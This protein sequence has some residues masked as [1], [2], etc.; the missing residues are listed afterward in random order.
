MNNPNPL[1]KS[2][3]KKVFRLHPQRVAV[4]IAATLIIIFHQASSS[5]AQA[6]SVQVD[7]NSESPL[8]ISLLKVE[9]GDS[10]LIH[11]MVRNAGDKPISTYA[12]RH[13][14]VVGDK[15]TGGLI[16][17]DSP[18][19]G[20]TL[21]PGE[22]RETIIGASSKEAQQIKLSVDFVEFLDGKTW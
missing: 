11:L 17:S 21:Q 4:L 19:Q 12:V 3:M 1:R 6:P 7:D 2:S 14:D 16:L 15:N 20:L 13:D 5:F 8:R 22:S 10:L 9:Q 18:T